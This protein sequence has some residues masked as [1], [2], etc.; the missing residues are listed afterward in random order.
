[1]SHVD[2]GILRLPFFEPRHVGLAERIGE[3]LDANAALCEAPHQ[4]GPEGK[5]LAILRALGADGW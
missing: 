2:E 5:G 3:W 4:D 1:M